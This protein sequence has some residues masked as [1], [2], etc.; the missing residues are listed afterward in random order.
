MRS[1]HLWATLA[2]AVVLGGCSTADDPGPGPADGTSSAGDPS[3]GTAS[4]SAGQAEGPQPATGMVLSSELASLHLPAGQPWTEGRGGLS[5]HLDIDARNYYQVH[6]SHGLGQADDLD[7][8]V[9]AVLPTLQGRGP[10]VARVEDRDLSGV[11]VAVLSG[12]DGTGY[13]YGIVAIHHGLVMTVDFV[14][15]RKDA[16]ADAW[17]ESILASLEWK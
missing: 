2:L 6:L 4:P 8:A 12:V 14:F 7:T 17:I 3:G 16:Q 5:G 13:Y 1:R 11:E 10:E 15:P 9:A